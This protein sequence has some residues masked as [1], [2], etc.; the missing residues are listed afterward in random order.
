MMNGT[1]KQ[2]RGEIAVSR[3]VRAS[4][5]SFRDLERIAERREIIGNIKVNT[6]VVRMTCTRFDWLYKCLLADDLIPPKDAEELEARCMIVAAPSGAGKSHL[7]RRLREHPALVPSMDEYGPLRP[8]VAVKAPSP[9]TLTTLGLKLNQVLTGKWL[10]SYYKQHEVWTEFY[11]QAEG[12]GVAVVMIDEAHHLMTARNREECHTVV[13]TF[14]NLIVPNP[15]DPLRL[16]GSTLRPIM[17]VIGGMPQIVRILEKDKQLLRRRLVV[18]IDPWA[19]DQSGLE[20]ATKFLSLVETK[21]GFTGTEFLSDRDMVRRM[22]AASNGYGGRMMALVKEASFLA[23]G[24]NSSQLDREKHLAK[25]FEEIFQL[26]PKK[27]PFLV[28]DVSKCKRVPEKSYDRLSLLRGTGD[29]IP[30]DDEQAPA[31]IDSEKN[32]AAA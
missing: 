6:D 15:E 26:G 23:I 17:L 27:N 7:M 9:C 13:E 3:R 29:E 5:F 4:G 1:I 12:Q 22:M 20:R 28:A 16:P 10:P 11:A 8:L 32:Q 21:L 18:K 24:S 2:D 14:K 25:V 30:G 31:E 19:N